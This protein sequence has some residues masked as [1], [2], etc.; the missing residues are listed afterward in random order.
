ME[1]RRDFFRRSYL[2]VFIPSLLFLLMTLSAL[3]A[4]AASGELPLT[5]AVLFKNGIG[6]FEHQGIVKDQETVRISIT[7]SQLDD[8]LKSLT[9]LDLDGGFIG[10]IS[11]GSSEPLERQLRDLGTGDLRGKDL[12]SI[13]RE[14]TG[15]RLEAD[16][17]GGKVYGRLLNADV[18]K[19][20]G[21][22]GTAAEVIEL[23]LYT[24]G[25]ELRTVTMQ[26]LQGLRFASES[27]R[28]DLSLF[29][30]V[31][32]KARNDNTRILEIKT[33][34]SGERTVKIS[35]AVEAPIW[36]ASYRLILEDNKPAFLQG[37]AIVDNTTSSDWNNVTLSLVSSSPVSFIHRLSDPVYARRPEVPVSAGPQLAPELHEGG[38]SAEALGAV[39]GMPEME[40]AQQQK[41]VRMSSRNFTAPMS[42]PGVPF[43]EAMRDSNRT[44][45][46]ALKV[47]DQFEYR[48]AEPVTLQKNQ[49]A[50]IP[51]LQTEIEAEKN[52]VFTAGRGTTS[53]RNAVWLKNVTVL[54]LDGGPFSINDSGLFAGEGL[55]DTVYPGERRLLSYALDRA[56]TIE[57]DVESSRRSF[58]GITRERGILVVSHKLLESKVYRIKNNADSDRNI[59][60]EHPLRNGW[61]LVSPSSPEEKS[62]NYY[63]FKIN[64]DQ[65]A[66]I[67]FTV[68]EERIVSQRISL[69]SITENEIR[70]WMSG[71]DMD[72]KTREKLAPLVSLARNIAESSKRIRSFDSTKVSIYGSQNRVRQNL[73]ALGSSAAEAGLRQRY[74]NQM[75]EQEDQL[76]G[77]DRQL[78]SEKIKLDQLQSRFSEMISSIE[79]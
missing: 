46:E 37:W 15:T 8:V 64:M 59:V 17:P 22:D 48:M 76:A 68:Q 23:A 47:G 18:R 19:V 61:N 1:I 58:H 16:A 36:K 2:M 44:S 60:I 50:L 54:T 41:A 7:S 62:G 45:A 49:S 31:V 38:M 40:M 79:F 28:Q 72:D 13:L 21:G 77:L 29:L 78:S 12:A 42:A 25:G 71:A 14:L 39:A 34:G 27:T 11:Y 70:V 67:S 55:F 56:V 9:V 30:D 43:S 33:L 3:P 65:K 57:E 20:A 69:D 10:A 4:T 75:E 35:Y 74:V 5:R 24:D 73:S 51:I 66:A 6:F 32:E 63:R 52:S 53:P 26:S